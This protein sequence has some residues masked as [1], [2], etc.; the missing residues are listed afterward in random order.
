MF[1]EG[2]FLDGWG[3]ASVCT[4]ICAVRHISVKKG[5]KIVLNAS[6][7]YLK[8]SKLSDCRIT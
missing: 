3:D 5:T 1:L 6:D 8:S 4:M 2:G 7:L